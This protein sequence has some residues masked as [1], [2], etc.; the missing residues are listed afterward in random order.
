MKMGNIKE[1]VEDMVMSQR[2]RKVLLADGWCAEEINELISSYFRGLEMEE[3]VLRKAK[4]MFANIVEDF[5][6]KM[7][8]ETSSPTMPPGDKDV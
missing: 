1:I 4:E 7:R 6:K 8:D 2:L 5:V 3:Q